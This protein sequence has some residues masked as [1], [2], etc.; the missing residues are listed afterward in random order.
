[1]YGDM[2]LFMNRQKTEDN[3][4]RL[5]FIEMIKDYCDMAKE[6]YDLDDRFNDEFVIDYINAQGKEPKD[7]LYEFIQDEDL[8]LVI[9][10]ENTLDILI[11][12]VEIL[13]YMEEREN[14]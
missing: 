6:M 11:N 10:E 2:N 9:R 8:G 14:D 4:F 5:R 3:S 12:L 13:R 7:T 1:M